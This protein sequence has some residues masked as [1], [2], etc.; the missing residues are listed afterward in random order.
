MPDCPSHLLAAARIPGS[1]CGAPAQPRPTDPFGRAPSPRQSSARPRTI[2]RRPS[3]FEVRIVT[4]RPGG[5]CQLPA[6]SRARSVSSITFWTPVPDTFEKAV[7]EIECPDDITI[8]LGVEKTID[9]RVKS[10]SV[11][12]DLPT[13]EQMVQSDQ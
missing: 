2:R 13:P 5:Q 9:Q 12:A 3:R 8:A 4:Q 11:V 10:C 6:F 1:P 7:G